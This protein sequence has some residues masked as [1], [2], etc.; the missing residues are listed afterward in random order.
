[1]GVQ[2]WCIVGVTAVL[3]VCEVAVSQLCHSLILLMDSFHTFYILMHSLHL[4]L[5]RW[6]GHSAAPRPPPESSTPPP[7][8]AVPPS[9]VPPAISPAEP[10][11]GSAP[12]NPGPAE[13]PPPPLSCGLSYRNCRTEV[14]G[15]FLAALFL[16]SL[17]ISGVLEI[18][19][20]FL[21]PKP[22]RHHL[23][24]VA[25]SGSSLLLKMLVLW[26]SWERGHMLKGT[27]KLH[28]PHNRL[29]NKWTLRAH[30]GVRGAARGASWNC[31]LSAIILNYT[32]LL[33]IYYQ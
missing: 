12:G 4:P 13:T 9:S 19:G 28:M 30:A 8:P 11:P 7:P 24:L 16:A 20:L 23:L 22:V 33:H 26:W 14:V 15:N 2:Q 32:I 29:C 1:M 10:L 21:G 17:C 3:L 6:R 27:S 31:Q 18:I 5:T 25:V